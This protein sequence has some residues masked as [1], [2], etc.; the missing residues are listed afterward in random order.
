MLRARLIPKKYYFYQGSVCRIDRVNFKQNS[1]HIFRLDID[2]SEVLELDVAELRL[3]PAYKIGE[4]AKILDRKVDTIRKYERN[5]ILPR[6]RTFMNGSVEVRYYSDKDIVEMAY[7]FATQD[8]VGR[9]V[10]QRTGHWKINRANLDKS[11]MF[12]RK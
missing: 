10:D 11:L 4:V 3:E 1:V 2:K 6:P 9:P 7:R 5:G 8:P 12:R